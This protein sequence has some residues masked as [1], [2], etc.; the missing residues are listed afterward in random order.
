MMFF[1][2]FFIHFSFYINVSFG[3]IVTSLKFL[4]QS[5][6]SDYVLTGESFTLSCSYIPQNQDEKALS[7]EFLKDEEQVYFYDLV[8][9]R[10]VI[11]G[12]F[13]EQVDETKSSPSFVLIQ[14]ANVH[15]HGNYTC[16]VKS[17]ISCSDMDT[18]LTI[19]NDACKESDWTMYSDMVHCLEVIRLE[20]IGMFP[21]PIPS[22]GV[23]EKN[24]GQFLKAEPFSSIDRLENGSY[25]LYMSHKYS[26][27]EYRKKIGDFYF[28]CTFTI[29]GTSW[30]RT[31]NSHLFARP[32]CPPPQQ[33]DHGRYTLRPKSCWNVPVEGS[34]L[35]YEC[36][37][38]HTL[39][40]PAELICLNGEW[41]R[42]MDG[43]II[44][45]RTI[46]L[47]TMNF[48]PPEDDPFPFCNIASYVSSSLSLFLV[49]FII[50]HMHR[51]LI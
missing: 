7:V 46:N 41:R 48:L 30:T 37:K 14:R 28:K 11:S 49:H 25:H 21:K 4:S 5:G 23:F 35:T 9:N 44:N 18:K 1:L 12:V 15:M 6:H 17:E 20:C 13:K 19:I 31:I 26:A 38:N 27:D 47:N 8:T 36:D 51:L 33:V 45:T 32:G 29:L 3:V 50:I 2:L 10:R 42:P 40:K 16:K 22:C 39:S 34:I 43:E 24:S